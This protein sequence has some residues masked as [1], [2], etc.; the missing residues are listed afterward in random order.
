MNEA[1][2]TT[3]S[4]AAAVVAWISPL[5]QIY[6]D[7][8]LRARLLFSVKIEICAYSGSTQGTDRVVLNVSNFGPG[9]VTINGFV[10]SNHRWSVKHLSYICVLPG[11]AYSSPPPRHLKMGELYS[12][13]FPI[14]RVGWLSVKPKRVGVIDAFGRFHWACSRDI[15]VVFD[16]I[17]RRCKP[18]AVKGSGR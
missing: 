5:W 13:S 15:D 8:R 16:E 7:L 10:V 11:S 9:D 6:R 2:L 12:T 14:E 18:E 1:R 17:K 3:I 4:I